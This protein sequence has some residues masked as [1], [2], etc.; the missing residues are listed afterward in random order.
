MSHKTNGIPGL[1][2]A[3][4]NVEE[5]M[6]TLADMAMGTDRNASP[7]ASVVD[8]ATGGGGGRGG[9]DMDTGMGMDMG[10]GLPMADAGGH[11]CH[12]HPGTIHR[13]ERTGRFVTARLDHVEQ[14]DPNRAPDRGKTHRNTGNG[15]AGIDDAVALGGGTGC[16]CCRGRHRPPGD[17]EGY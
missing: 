12:S 4:K 16:N 1:G 15:R 9:M 10:G 2:P 3:A 14:P 11:H 5:T 17:M 13:D 7:G 6:G 8:A